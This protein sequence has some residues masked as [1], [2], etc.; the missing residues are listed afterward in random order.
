MHF[1]DSQIL[2]ALGILVSA[3]L[4]LPSFNAPFVLDDYFLFLNIDR[5]SP[6][7]L[8]SFI[9]QNIAWT[10]QLSQEGYY[11]W[12]TLPEI[13]V[14]FFRPLSSFL[15]YMDHLLFGDHAIFF[16]IHSFIWLGA[17]ITAYGLLLRRLLPGKI[18][19]LAF[20][21][22]ILDDAHGFAAFWSANRHALVSAV[23][24]FWGLLA[25]IR[26]REEHW[27][28]GY[29]LSH[30]GFAL[31]L[32]SGEMALSALVY[33]LSYEIFA[34]PG[35][36]T[37]RIKSLATLAVI[38]ALYFLFYRG[39]GYGTFGSDF[40]IDPVAHFPTYLYALL[41]RVPAMLSDIILGVLAD[42]W[43]ISPVVQYVQ[44]ALGAI[45]M[46][47]IVFVF[48]FCL[49]RL[50][51]KERKTILW[52]TVG[53][54]MALLPAA[55]TYPQSRQLLCASFGASAFLAAVIYQGLD[56][57]K[58]TWKL[59]PLK[60]Q[61]LVGLGGLFAVS[62]II[63]A[64]AILLFYQFHWR[65]FEKALQEVAV[66]VEGVEDN[67]RERHAIVLTSPD[68]LITYYS[69]PL[70]LVYKK[71]LPL[72]WKILSFAPFDHIVT[73]TGPKTL[74]LE[75]KEGCFLST[76][77]EKLFRSSEFA[78]RRGDKVASGVFTAYIEDVDQHG[79]TK[80]R[81]EF[82]KPLDDPSLVF[83]SWQDGRFRRQELPPL[84]ESKVLKKVSGPSGIL[85][86]G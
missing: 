33:I 26:W 43:F 8:Y 59:P 44:I 60:K 55:T 81:F 3:L 65:G 62:H 37:Q 63:V 83:L 30:L 12:W 25:Y 1:K 71:P 64:P 86:K 75:L 53:S 7:E 79:P 28:P 35:P 27:K 11:P 70:R 16:H 2:I 58:E 56:A 42:I 45:S 29:Y 18:G 9:P 67:F 52:L 61:I 39:L 73:R 36:W 41:T 74:L 46:V 23:F 85:H 20:F 24:V 48:K 69:F 21:L 13:K 84:G 82:D 10:N 32:L 76:S 22:C 66:N 17:L 19:I 51:S 31:G 68:H 40:W 49:T 72:C 6:F 47:I 5:G 38:G 50:N 34:G 80:I 54:V 15:L 4:F 57:L 77:M 14:T 78:F